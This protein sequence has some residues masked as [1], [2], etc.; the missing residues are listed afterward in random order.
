MP[1]VFASWVL[2]AT[3][4]PAAKALAAALSSGGA[5]AWGGSAA[6]RA[7]AWPKWSRSSAPWIVMAMVCSVPSMVVTVK[8]SVKV[9]QEGS[10]CTAQLVVSSV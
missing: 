6:L 8:V 3:V 10:A 7:A 4:G 9:S 1:S 5:V 2:A